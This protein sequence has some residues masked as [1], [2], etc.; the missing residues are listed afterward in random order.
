MV[1][2]IAAVAVNVPLQQLFHYEVPADLDGRLERGHRVLIPF[3]R[4]TTTGVC[5]DFP[6]SAEVER[7]K[8]LRK[9]LH[10]EC[11]FDDH[12]LEFT[13]WIAEYYQVGWGEVLEAALPP[14]IRA[15]RSAREVT[16]IARARRPEQLASEAE[17]WERTAPARARLLRA[18]SAVSGPIPRK[19]LLGRA[20]AQSGAVRWLVDNGWATEEKRAVE[21][22]RV[23]V[24]LAALESRSTGELHTQ[25]AAA[26]AEV[27]AAADEQ[28]FA[29]FLLHG[30]T[31][32]G[33][34]EVYLRALRHVLEGG[35]RGLV[36]LPEISLTPQTVQRFRQ[37]LPEYEVAV[38]H[39]MLTGGERTRFWHEIQAGR[40]RL[41]IG[42]RSAVF[43]PIPDLG[44]IVVDEEHE[45]SY[46]QESSP[47]YHAR[48]A[49]V[50]RASMLGIP[51]V[52]GSATPSLESMHNAMTGRYHHLKM[53]ERVTSHALP[54][55]S[56]ATLDEDFYRPNGTGLIGD[57]L[58][59]LIRERLRRRE[60]ILLFLNR[61]GFSTYIHCPR[62]G[63]VARCEDCDISLTFHRREGR[64]RCHYCGRSR[65]LESACPDC[66][67]PGV[68][69]S[70]VGTEK[71][72]AEL[73]RRYDT[74]RIARL[75]RDAI[76]SHL[77]M[78]ETIAAFA[79]GEF[80]I[81]VG[82]QMVAKGHDFPGVS[83]VGIINA[84]TGLHFPDFRAAERS[85]QL[86]TQVAGRA[87]RGEKA[88]RVVVQTFHP[89]HYAI[90]AAV[91]G[92]DEEFYRREL[93]ERR[94]FEYPPFGYLAR[95][96][97]QGE[98]REKV[99]A[100]ARRTAEELRADPLGCAILGPV[101]AP[102][103]RVQKRHRRQVLI[104]SGSRRATQELLARFRRS[105]RRSSVERIIDV[106]PHSML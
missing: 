65:D 40:A 95:V 7:L 82:T 51:V 79:R 34:T 30:V 90:R 27:D 29:P 25:Q 97:L 80:D 26:L 70:G 69:R 92:E 21:P 59:R 91:R 18:L 76:A 83:L 47:R 106:D 56:S 38:L 94:Q 52:L 64:L 99:E 88:G 36:L 11:R 60:Q 61:R 10:P 44:L 16:W 46:K 48:D 14:S 89:E 35:R 93:E 13:R 5:V 77:A 74:T 19:D 101:P 8:P 105:S 31:G 63:Y 17:R 73:E 39:S 58:D 12:L 103:A 72:V 81:L 15:A 45:P 78:E 100:E 1:R 102:I 104:K 43:A 3:G 85:F 55:I 49:A 28:R 66:K 23:E 33:K 67:M 37:G 41:V 57:A 32:S 54:V 86:I 84:D 87:G 75:D 22:L 4:R 68:R 2:P 42:A 20:E 24:D 96:L 53:P 62:C 9:I 50:V 71:V 98:Q 6:E